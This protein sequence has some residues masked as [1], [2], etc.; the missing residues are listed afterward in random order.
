M[1]EGPQPCVL[2]S[3]RFLSQWVAIIQ[4]PFSLAMG[5]D[6]YFL[7]YNSLMR[8]NLSWTAATSFLD[9]REDFPRCRVVNIYSDI[10]VQV[11][12]GAVE[13]ELTQGL[14]IL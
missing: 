9:C 4:F 2:F 14:L 5:G 8:R 7:F 10:V 12:A 11:E 1:W 13:E 3:F 6:F